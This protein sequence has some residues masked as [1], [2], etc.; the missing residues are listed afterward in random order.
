MSCDVRYLDG[1]NHALDLVS[2]FVKKKSKKHSK[3]KIIKLLKDRWPLRLHLIT[4]T[5]DTSLTIKSDH[6]ETS[7]P[8]RNPHK[9]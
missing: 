9:K 4:L 6:Q 1:R 3:K 2:K 5:T 7:I 8:L